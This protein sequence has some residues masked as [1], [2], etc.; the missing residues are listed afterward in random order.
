MK[1]FENDYR[2]LHKIIPSITVPY[3]MLQEP[4]NHLHILL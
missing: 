3:H 2:S 1:E 4:D